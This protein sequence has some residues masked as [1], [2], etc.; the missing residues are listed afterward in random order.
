MQI[1][2]GDVIEALLAIGVRI[3]GLMLFAPFLGSVVIPARIKAALTLALTFL[4]YPMISKTLPPQPL[5]EWPLLVFR[6][7]L[8][9][10]AIGIATSI[11]FEAVQMAGQVLSIQMGYSL[12]N[13]LDPNTQVDTTVVAMFHQSIAMLIFLRLDVHLWLLRAIGNSFGYLPPGAAQLTRPFTLSLIGAGAMILSIGVQIA[14]PVLSATLLTDIVLGLLGK[15]SPQLPLM[16]LGPAVKS[17]LG[18][19]ILFTSLKYWPDMFRSLFLNSMG[20]ADRLMHLAR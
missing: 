9:G 7:L 10:V 16:V 2:F 17:L 13:I 20:Y 19:T 3:S 14:A 6:E 18:L 1:P 5:S 11:V 8:V 4:M 15:A 12:V